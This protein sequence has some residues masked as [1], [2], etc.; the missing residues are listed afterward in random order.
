MAALLE[1]GTLPER[2]LR[3]ID[4]TNVKQ[5][6]CLRYKTQGFTLALCKSKSKGSSYMARSIPWVHIPC[7]TLPQSNAAREQVH[8]I[9]PGKTLLEQRFPQRIVSPASTASCQAIASKSTASFSLLNWD[10]LMNA[11]RPSGIIRLQGT[12]KDFLL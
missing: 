9:A 3:V 10:A 1:Q 5:T 7:T 2:W 6:P 4:E 12:A 11:L 8:A